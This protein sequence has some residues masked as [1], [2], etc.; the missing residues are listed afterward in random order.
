MLLRGPLFFV[1]GLARSG[2]SWTALA[3]TTALRGMMIYEPYNSDFY[4]DRR[5]FEMR[6]LPSGSADK[7]FLSVFKRELRDLNRPKRTFKITFA[8]AV[9]VK[10]VHAG[11]ATEA[12]WERFRPNVVIIIRN[13]FAL[14]ASW[15]RVG[16]ASDNRIDELLDQPQL[17][18]DHLA[19]FVDHMRSSADP[20]FKIGAFWGASYVVMQRLAQNHPEW[21]WVTHESLCEQPEAGFDRLL[22]HFGR[23]QSA[24]GAAFLANNNRPPTADENAFSVARVAEKQPTKWLDELAPLQVDAIRSGC[25]PF[26]L[27]QQ[28]YPELVS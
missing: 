10:D 15:Q 20:F 4:P 27:L 21:Y 7:P 8:R 22:A 24:H 26:G 19:P 23:R 18:T 3:I 12:L 2:T 25:A 1:T 9:I 17:V 6:Y 5:Q 11:L 16:F 13:P 28:L 14:A